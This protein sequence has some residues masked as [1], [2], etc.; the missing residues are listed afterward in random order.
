MDLALVKLY[1]SKAVQYA[2][3]L[4]YACTP[5]IKVLLAKRIEVWEVTWS[6]ALLNSAA[7]LCGNSLFAGGAV[8][9]TDVSNSTHVASRLR[10]STVSPAAVGMY[11]CLASNSPDSDEYVGRPVTISVLG[12]GL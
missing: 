11:E 5:Y 12:K 3:S 6:M 10:L 7:C 1:F 4:E 2:Q 8:V 9:I